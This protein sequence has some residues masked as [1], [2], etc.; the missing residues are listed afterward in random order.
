MCLIQ[1][2]YL[3]YCGTGLK[4]SQVDVLCMRLRY[5]MHPDAP[6]SEAG[7]SSDMQF[8]IMITINFP[9]SFNLSNK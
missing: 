7:I 6:S 9:S 3:Q 2:Q 4:T 5:T 8:G 1:G